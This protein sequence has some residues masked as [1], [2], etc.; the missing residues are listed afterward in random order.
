METQ[1]I[2]SFYRHVFGDDYKGPDN[3]LF[4]NN[5]SDIG[6]FNVFSIAD[7]HRNA[8]EK[9]TMPYNRRSYYKISLIKGRN[10]VEYADKTVDI[11]KH[12][13]LFA[14]PKIPYKYNTGGPNQQGHFCVFT[15]DFITKTNAGVSIDSLPVFSPNSDFVYQLN[16]TQYKEIEAVFKR[17]GA[18]YEIFSSLYYNLICFVSFFAFIFFY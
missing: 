5:G 16:A 2:Q 15:R 13:V 18:P 4:E 14:T 8:S 6:H 7:V 1:S 9:A 12:A 11:E 3:F 17:S 10:R